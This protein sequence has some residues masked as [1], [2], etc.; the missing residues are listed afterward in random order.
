MPG[1]ILANARVLTMDP[2]RPSADSVA[3]KGGRILWVGSHADVPQSRGARLV[4][5]GGGT[6]LPAFHDAH[7]HLLAYASSLSAVDCR[8]PSVSSIGDIGQA[9]T[10]RASNTPVGEW[11]R[12]WGYDET[13]LAERRHPTRRDLDKFAPRHPLRLDHRSGHACVLNSLAL[14][15]VGIGMSFSEPPGATVAREL[16]SGEPSGLLFEMEDYL[17]G[18]I[19][20]PSRERIE[21]SLKRASENLL[22]YG[23][24]S[25]QDATHVNSVA[26]WEF[27]DGLS[28]SIDP[29]PRITLMPGYRHLNE[30][31]ERGLRFGAYG[32]HLRLGHVKIMATASSGR[33]TPDKRE[34]SRMIAECVESGFPVAVHAVESHVVRSVAESLSAIPG[35]HLLGA[36]HRVEHASECPPDALRAVAR[37]SA[38]VATQP[39]FIYQNGDRYRATVERRTL[40]YLYRLRAFAE[41]GVDVAFSSDAPVGDPNPM[42]GIYAAVERRTTSGNIIAP[43]ERIAVSDALERY[44]SVS[45]RAAGI[46]NEV[47]GIA[48]GTLADM[49]L[50]EEDITSVAPE[51]LADSRP[52]MTMLGGRIAWE[53]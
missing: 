19:P 48:P 30:F 38:M 9:V 13:S 29:I 35:S 5:C 7:I 51:R 36:P 21:T 24:T 17:D 28:E 41:R 43:D 47:G 3:V 8:P 2:R 34:L 46:E 44:T 14:E 50:F 39:V 52:V 27:L 1:L 37:S 20:Q 18:R 22:A 6:L 12:A 26:R 49:V 10:R 23:V 16:D 11:I 53:A 15:R 33:Q 25:V 31:V 45:A 42:R 4:D 40:P 32:L